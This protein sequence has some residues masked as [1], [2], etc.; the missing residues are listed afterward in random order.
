MRLCDICPAP[1]FPAAGNFEIAPPGVAKDGLKFATERDRDF[2]AILLN[3]HPPQ[4]RSTLRPK[5]AIVGLSPAANQID[6][7]V[8]AYLRSGD[9]GLASVA[10]A[11]AGLAGS[12]IAMMQGLGLSEKLGI[13]FPSSTLA[14][15][16]DVY[17]T[18]LVACATL[19]TS[20]SSDAFDPS[21]YGGATRCII[22]RFVN[23]M[24]APNFLG[25]R[26]ILILGSD[27][28]KSVNHVKLTS[29][30]TVAE[31]LRASG[32]LVI[33]MPHPSG[34]NGEYVALAADS[35]EG[36]RAFRFD[37]AWDSEMMAPR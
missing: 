30:Q 1:C 5:V 3:N 37:G 25:L 12:I 23:E 18:S 35:G 17:V 6:E 26:A 21:R 33:P 28:W 34:Q 16:P 24:L 4:F 11:F 20:G 31:A 13:S 29:G 15:H 32:K 19:D 7:F 14:R 9:Y 8:S 22:D 27:G 2:Y 36:A 10:G